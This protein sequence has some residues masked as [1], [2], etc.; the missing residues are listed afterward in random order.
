MGE[1]KYELTIAYIFIKIISVILVII[2]S[3]F[4]LMNIFDFLITY[5]NLSSM[6]YILLFPLIFP[7][8]VFVFMVYNILFW[9]ILPLRKYVDNINKK[10]W[11]PSVLEHAISLFKIFLHT[12][13]F[14]IPIL[15]VFF[16]IYK[17]YSESTII[18]VAILSTLIVWHIVMVY[19]NKN[20]K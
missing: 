8:I 16:L 11:L 20:F 6:V 18:V 9:F 5:Y 3:F 12:L 10:N 14:I 7:S 4:L 13:L 1:N 2:I 17:W 15:I 19:I